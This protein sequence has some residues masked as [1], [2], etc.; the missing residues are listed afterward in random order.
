MLIYFR[1]AYTKSFTRNF[2]KQGETLEVAK[3]LAKAK[4]AA[5]FQPTK[6]ILIKNN[7]VTGKCCVTAME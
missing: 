4:W 6:L 2:V 7:I 3:N 5:K 1:W